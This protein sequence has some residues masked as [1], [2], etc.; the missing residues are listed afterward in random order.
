M[1]KKYYTPADYPNMPKGGL[2][3]T[4]QKV[5]FEKWRETHPGKPETSRATGKPSALARKQAAKYKK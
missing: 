3:T 4:E 2:R 1:P 5:A